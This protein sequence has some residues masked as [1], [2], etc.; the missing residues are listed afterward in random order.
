MKRSILFILLVLLPLVVF[1]QKSVTIVVIGEGATKDEATLSA[2]RSA[3]EQSFGAFV[4]SN[5]TMLNDEL[6]QDE[7]VSVSSGNI[8]NYKELSFSKMDNGH[9]TVSIEAT[10]SL[11]KLASF[12]QSRGSDCELAGVTFGANLQMAQFYIDAEGKTIN[13]LL[14]ELRLMLPSMY[15]YS[16]S[17]RNPKPEEVSRGKNPSK[18]ELTFDV[19]ITANEASQQFC[20]LLVN[21]LNGLSMNSK[22]ASSFRQ[23][24]GI[25]P[26]EFFIDE[27]KGFSWGNMRF[28]LRKEE[29]VEAIERFINNSLV[30]SMVGFEIVDNLGIKHRPDLRTHSVNR[31]DERQVYAGNFP[32]MGIHFLGSEHIGAA[33]RYSIRYLWKHSKYKCS[34][35][36][37][38][39]MNDIS[40]YRNFSIHKISTTAIPY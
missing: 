4:S 21:T 24:T 30:S 25:T 27:D 16:V 8:Q 17:V 19:T 34:F 6:I 12:A 28:I 33:K 2:L 32:D 14:R 23:I 1:A 39:P 35:S 13:H 20:N 7:I 29:N 11:A 18:Y 10:V 31:Y 5:T 15:D 9:C 40:K 3:I 26:I 36:I 37:K 22:T 38:V